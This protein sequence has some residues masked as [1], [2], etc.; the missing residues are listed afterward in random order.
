M[1]AYQLMG[2]LTNR[3]SAASVIKFSWKEIQE[4]FKS[5]VDF[6]IKQSVKNEIIEELEFWK[7]NRTKIFILGKTPQHIPDVKAVK[8]L[9]YNLEKN[10]DYYSIVQ[11]IKQ[12]KKRKTKMLQNYKFR[13]LTSK[14]GIY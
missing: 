4:T 7:Q 14:M 3:T 1:E 9:L 10:G 12:L 6:L 11:R 5:N 8:I 13:Y 2:K